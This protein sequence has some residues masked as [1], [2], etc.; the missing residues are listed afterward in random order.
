MKL[1]NVLSKSLRLDQKGVLKE[2]GWDST[3]SQGKT[4]YVAACLNTQSLYFAKAK[5]R[6]YREISGQLRE[7]SDHP[8]LDL[9]KKPNDFQTFWELKYLI[10]L[11]FGVKGNY[12]ILKLKGKITQTPQMLII[13]DPTRVKPKSSGN[14]WIDHYEYDTGRGEPLKLQPEEV[15]HLRFPSENSFIEGKP[16]IESIGDVL[17]VDKYQTYYM[18]KFHKEGGFMGAVFTTNAA[19]NNTAY[20]RALEMLRQKYSG[21]EASF[22]V[23]LFEQ[24][25]QPIKAAY[26]LKDMEMS[27]QRKLTREE[28]MTAFRIP[29]L[30]LGGSAEGYT[31]ASSEAAE[32][33]YTSTFIDPILDY[34]DEV[35]TQHVKMDYGKNLVIK[36]DAVAPK[37]VERNLKYYKDLA[38]VG[39]L[40]VNEIRIA[41]DYDAFDYE[42]AKVPLINVGGA[43]IRLDTGEQLG[44]VPNNAIQPQKTLSKSITEYD[45][46]WKQFDRRF[47]R[48][49][50]WFKRQ[51]NEFFDA[52][53]K[54]LLDRL[55]QKSSFTVE[56]FISSQDEMVI[57]MNMFENAL[58][59]F[60]E[61]GMNFAG[62][63]NL[64]A[65]EIRNNITQLVKNSTSI[66]ETTKKELLK[67]L[68]NIDDTDLINVIKNTYK[69]FREVRSDLIATTTVESA[70][71]LGVW[72]S[73]KLQ[74]FKNKIW[75]SQRDT[76]VRDSHFIADGQKVNIDEPFQVGGELLQ[77]P[78]DPAGSPEE[79][80]NCRCTL[81][82][83]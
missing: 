65:P 63:V 76:Q 4:G 5:F 24:G 80:I 58:M 60:I 51:V 50:S 16:I 81:I 21:S 22:K 12:Y 27:E 42:L 66:N 45:L 31:K 53:E 57:I 30:L 33:T 29:Q 41:E 72:T 77:Y 82:A 44:Q 43:V 70:F 10:G 40:V 79:T 1:L 38:S 56:D 9:L 11:Y 54:R 37:D 8:F 34:V 47:G 18:K 20:N 32:Y 6:L 7:I 48:E 14:K 49:I 2:L 26:S 68:E 19:L 39:G 13:L 23:A 61:R 15:I 62:K 36:H 46:H 78:G 83:E 64:D 35:L 28:V 59:R 55:N 73:Y 67:S 3:E 17:D 74:G 75:I 52:Q 69:N 71:N 25:L